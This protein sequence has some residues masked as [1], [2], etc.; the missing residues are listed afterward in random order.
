MTLDTYQS[1]LQ[2]LPV[3]HQSFTTK[4]SNWQNAEKQIDWLQILNDQLFQNSS[5]LELSRRNLFSHAGTTREL[6]VKTIYWGY[7]NGM[8]GNNF[9]NIL[10]NIELLEEALDSLR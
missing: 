9:T 1:L 6:I 8:R 7:P 4:R 3:M 5:E 10:R 2:S